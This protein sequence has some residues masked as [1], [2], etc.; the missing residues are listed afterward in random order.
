L[1][2]QPS[3]DAEERKRLTQLERGYVIIADSEERNTIIDTIS[4]MET[5][6]IVPALG[7]LFAIETDPELKEALIEAVGWGETTDSAKAEVYVK[8]LGADQPASVRQAAIE[9]LADLDAKEAVPLLRPLAEDTDQ[10]VRAAA[11]EAIRSFEN[12]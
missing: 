3:Q 6:A 5:P 7:R 11:L 8:A 4:E 10:E 2:N 12:P 1:Q 9:G